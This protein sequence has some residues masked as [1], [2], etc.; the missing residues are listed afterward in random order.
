MSALARLGLRVCSKIQRTLHRDGRLIVISAMPKSG[1]TFLSRAVASASG[2]AHSFLA[3]AYGNAEQELY[4]P[5]VI[6]AYGRGTVTQQHFK[7]NQHNLEILNA[8]RIRPVVLT[9]NVFDALVSARDH[10]V[11]ENLANL[12][13]VHVSRE[14][15]DLEPERQLDFVIDLFAPWYVAFFVSWHHAEG[16]G[17]PFL[18]MTYEE[19]VADWPGAVSRV[20]EFGGR[21]RPA[22]DVAGAVAALTGAPRER[23]RLNHGTVG[24]GVSLLSLAQRERVLRLTRHYSA[25]DFSRIT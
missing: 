19:A 21:S 14:F 1:S 8:F 6:D 13:G 20:L 9:R 25:V 24:R 18:W 11:Q 5:A 3:Y 16:A 15:R 23:T 7:A 22:E 2:Y 4:L 17:V 10:L 12:P